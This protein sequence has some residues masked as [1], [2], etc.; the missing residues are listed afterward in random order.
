MSTDVHERI[1]RP[2]DPGAAEVSSTR[3]G[4]EPGRAGPVFIAGPDRSGTTLIY[5][6]LASHPNISMVRR[7]NMW[8]YFHGRYGDLSD[9]ANFDRCLDDMLRYKRMRHLL[10]D[11]TQIRAEFLQGERTYGRLFALFHEHNAARNSKSRWGDKSLHTEHYIDRLFQEFPDARVIHIT[12]D[13]RDRYASVRKRYGRNLSRVGA[14]TGRWL[15][16]TRA[17][18]RNLDRYPDRYLMIRYEDLAREPERVMREVC[19]F[20]GEDFLPSLLLMDAAPDH[21]DSGGNSSFGDVEPGKISTRAIGRFRSVLSAYEIAF[22]QRN[23]AREMQ[24]LGYES[25]KIDLPAAK[26]LRFYAWDL[27]VN[28]A[29]MHGWIVLRRINL[30]RGELLPAF[31]LR[32]VTQPHEG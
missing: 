28:L 16:S 2:H 3:G 25:A 12:R 30:H 24:A 1:A 31:R 14:A 26:W 17:G 18:R 23:A 19:A 9:P 10:P 13:P 15:L 8:R 7:T 20:I 27:P 6:L 4:P 5:A 11:E 22:I 32:D 29:R 21:R